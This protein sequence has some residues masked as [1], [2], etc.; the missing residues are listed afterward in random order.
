MNIASICSRR[1]VTV[2]RSATLQQ[3]ALLMR[4]HHVGSLV[5]TEADEAGEH[6]VGIVTDRDF[7]IEVLAR[8]VDAASVEMGRIVDGRIVSAQHDSGVMEAIELMRAAGVRR[9]LVRG[10]DRQVLGMLSFDDLLEACVAELEALAGVLRK[11]Q[12]REITERSK[13]T[14]RLR[15]PLLIPMSVLSF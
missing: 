6:V 9:L 4:E 5:V 8:G 3:A 1:L 13:L 10:S 12:Q 15:P 11:S 14:E 2:D 7:A